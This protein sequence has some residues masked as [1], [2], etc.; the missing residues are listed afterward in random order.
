MAKFGPASYAISVNAATRNLLFN[1]RGARSLYLHNAASTIYLNVLLAGGI[2]SLAN[3]TR[4]K[5]V[6]TSSLSG[7]INKAAKELTLTSDNIIFSGTVVPG[8]FIVHGTNKLYGVAGLTGDNKLL[9]RGVDDDQT[10]AS[11]DIY[12]FTGNYDANSFLWVE[13]IGD[14]A[15]YAMSL[16][17]PSAVHL[18]NGYVGGSAVGTGIIVTSGTVQGGAVLA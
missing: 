8:D 9:L 7:S 14:A 1:G 15:P 17:N 2:I 10:A 16:P 5:K 4:L 18:Y 11:F 6:N 13:A 3:E 12:R